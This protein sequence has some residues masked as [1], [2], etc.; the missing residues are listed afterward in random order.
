MTY[1]KNSINSL[2][3]CEALALV[4]SRPPPTLKSCQRI[5]KMKYV[6]NVLNY[7]YGPT[8]SLQ[9]ISLISSSIQMLW[10]DCS[11]TEHFFIFFFFYCVQREYTLVLRLW[12]EVGLHGKQSDKLNVSSIKETFPWSLDTGGSGE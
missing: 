11:W 9:F 2:C 7:V 5:F 6:F 1:T 12:Q 3:L 10:N 8:V 4:G